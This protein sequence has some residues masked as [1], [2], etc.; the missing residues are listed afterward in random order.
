MKSLT[1]VRH[2]K[3]NWGNEYLKDIDRHLNE[4][5]Y[6]DAYILSEWY[7]KTQPVPEIILSSTA[8]RALSTALIFARTMNFK[9][10]N[11][12]LE[13]NIYEGTSENLL[14]VLKQQENSINKIML[15]GHNPGITNLCN[16]LCENDFFDNVSTCG[17]VTIQF[18]TKAWKE[19]DASNSK[20]LLYQFPKSYKND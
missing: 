10:N 6:S 18:D 20:L 17:I 12:I 11:F 3:S 8:T 7:F 5:G 4:R 1:L 19:I 13:K 2:A 16:D 9:M 15:F 14:A